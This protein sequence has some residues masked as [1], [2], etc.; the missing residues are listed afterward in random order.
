M[1]ACPT[2]CGA[3]REKTRGDTEIVNCYFNLFH[4]DIR[5]KIPSIKS[6]I[7]NK[8]QIKMTKIPKKDK[9]FDLEDR[10]YNF[11]KDVRMWVKK[12]PKSLI[13]IEDMKQLIKSSGSIGANYIEA[14]EA[15][16]KKDFIMRMR[17]SRKESKETIYWIKLI[18]DTSTDSELDKEGSRLLNESIQLTKICSSIIENSINK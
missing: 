4:N 16:S 12:L 11:A 5:D 18:L 15:L 10:T 7:P 17:I 2:L 3:S 9:V 13:N 1:P 8:S 6:Q 14:N